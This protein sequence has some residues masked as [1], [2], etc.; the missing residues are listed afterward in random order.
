MTDA[1]SHLG[2]RIAQSIWLFPEHKTILGDTT[3][4][5][6]LGRQHVGALWDFASRH[7]ESFDH[8]KYGPFKAKEQLPDLVPINTMAKL[9]A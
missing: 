9:N 4:L 3:V 2:R 6:P 7:P 1:G 5:E 8:V